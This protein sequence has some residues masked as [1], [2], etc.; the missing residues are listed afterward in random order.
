MHFFRE[1]MSRRQSFVDERPTKPLRTVFL[2]LTKAN[3]TWQEQLM[4]LS[5][6]HLLCK[7]SLNKADG[8]QNKNIRAKSKGK[9]V[10]SAIYL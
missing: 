3:E 10:A 5:K 1:D 8:G 6:R 7:H 4:D 2:K 9:A